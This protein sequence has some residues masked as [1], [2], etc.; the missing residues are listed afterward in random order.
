MGEAAW[1]FRP[2]VAIAWPCL[3]LWAIRAPGL[4]IVAVEA[5]GPRV[6]ARTVAALDEL[7]VEALAAKQAAKEKED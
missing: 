4:R 1:G 3:F 2:L 6:P 5:P 7:I